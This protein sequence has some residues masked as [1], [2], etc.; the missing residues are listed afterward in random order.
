MHIPQ[1]KLHWEVLEHKPQAGNE[2]FISINCWNSSTIHLKF[3]AGHW[4]HQPTC[5][6]LL[7]FLHCWKTRRKCRIVGKLLHSK[8]RH[9]W[10]QLGKGTLNPVSPNGKKKIKK[11]KARKAIFR[12]YKNTKNW[13][14]PQGSVACVHH[15]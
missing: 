10:Y 13:Y 5:A 7:C 4:T 3:R 14:N 9:F 11:K 2:Q 8:M 12:L 15:Y 1:S 6:A